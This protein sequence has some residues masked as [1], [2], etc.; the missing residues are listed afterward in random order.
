M[1][2]R[3]YVEQAIRLF[4]SEAKLAKVVGYSQNAIWRAKQSGRVSA[5]MAVRIEAVCA[6]RGVE[7]P[8]DKLCPSV[9]KPTKPRSDGTFPPAYGPT[10]RERAAL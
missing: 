1:S 4:K 7:I 5:I 9:F 8:R 3:I 10:R 2:S 6:A